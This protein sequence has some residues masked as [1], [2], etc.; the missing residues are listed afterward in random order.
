M[1]SDTDL[2]E[3]K[4]VKPKA[5]NVRS[6]KSP[7][8]PKSKRS[9]FL[10]IRGLGF[11]IVL[12]VSLIIWITTYKSLTGRNLPFWDFLTANRGMVTGIAYTNQGRS[13]IVRGKVVREGDIVDGY[14]VIK[15]HRDRVE[16]EKDG[17]I[18]VKRPRR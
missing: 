13:A 4:V 2:A 14:K 1:V 18:V 16:F 12:A 10:S 11:W 6:R 15:I 3:G 7:D 9:K 5:G 17:E 8:S